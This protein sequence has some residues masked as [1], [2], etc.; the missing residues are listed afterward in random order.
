VVANYTWSHSIDNISVDGNGFTTAADNYNLNINRANGDFDHRHSFNGSVIYRLPFGKGK[1]W[2]NNAS[3]WVDNIFGG[4]EIGS[5]IQKQDGSVYSISSQKSTR[6]QTG[7]GA[8]TS[9]ANYSG[10]RHFGKITYDVKGGITYYSSADLA[11]FSVPNAGEY[12]NSGRNAFRGPGYFNVDAN[13]KKAFKL[14]MEGH[15]ITFRCEAYNLLNNPNFANP[16]TTI[17]SASFGR[18]S[19]TVG[20][21]TS[22]RVLQLALRYDF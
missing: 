2:M 16:N 13:L 14:P 7:T 4:W 21:V 12:G 20:G 17:T 15:T 8:N 9:F 3:S 22:P 6:H 1:R 11:N 19:S 5:L 10:D 18:I